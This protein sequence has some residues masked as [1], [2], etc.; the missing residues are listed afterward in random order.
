M[1]KRTKGS[2]TAAISSKTAT[3]SAES[4]IVELNDRIRTLEI[5]IRNQALQIERLTD[6]RNM[7]QNKARAA[8]AKPTTPVKY[9]HNEVG[10]N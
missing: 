8:I 4:E 1:L 2:K 9:E 5:K 6:E 3:H 10:L 7:F